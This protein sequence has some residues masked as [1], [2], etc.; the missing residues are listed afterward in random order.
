MSAGTAG[1]STRAMRKL[2][3]VSKRLMNNGNGACGIGGGIGGDGCAP[4][5]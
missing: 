3:A 5:V 2:V 4:L 1:W